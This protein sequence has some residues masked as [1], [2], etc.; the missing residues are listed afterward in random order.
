[1]TAR[2]SRHTIEEDESYFVSMTDLMVGLLFIFIIMLMVFALQY[3]EA[4]RKNREAELEKHMTTERLV[5][6]Q[7]VRNDILESLQKYLRD[8]GITVEIVKDQ[9]VLR[10]PEEILFDKARA[11]ITKKATTRSMSCRKRLKQC[12][13]AMQEAIG[14]YRQRNAHRAEPQ[15]T[16]SS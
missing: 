7:Q 2:A 12:S 1:M 16:Q 9:G 6:A 3:R 11:E 15:S 4:E 5:N 13:L 14:R 8:H 10:L